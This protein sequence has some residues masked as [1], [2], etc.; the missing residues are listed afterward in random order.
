MKDEDWTLGLLL[1]IVRQTAQGLLERQG[2]VEPYGVKLL[3]EPARPV[4]FLPAET[5][6]GA[7]QADLFK[8]ILDELRVPVQEP[9][10]G[11]ALVVAVDTEAGQ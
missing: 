3:G 8:A 10:Y 9:L 6:P 4:T 2:V 11:V 7:E 1:E 5:L